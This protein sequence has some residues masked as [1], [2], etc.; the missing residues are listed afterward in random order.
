MPREFRLAMAYKATFNSH[1]P[2]TP[3]SVRFP[4]D[5]VI[6][7]LGSGRYVLLSRTPYDGV[8]VMS[9]PLSNASSASAVT[10]SRPWLT[11]LSKQLNAALA[12]LNSALL[13]ANTYYQ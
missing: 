2:A 5:Q 7:S 1:M 4:K 9:S 8:P 11:A 10:D 13:S 3:P 12:Q 6:A